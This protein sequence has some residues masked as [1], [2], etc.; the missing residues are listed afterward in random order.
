LNPLFEKEA[1]ERERKVVLE[2]IKMYHDNPSSH[3]M[4]KIKEVMYKSPFGLPIL[5]TSETV[6]KLSRE[7]IVKVFDPVYSGNNLIFC[8]VG[9]SNFDS[10][11][12]EA[13]KFP[14]KISAIKRIPIIPKNGEVT[15]TREG[16]DQAHL[17]FGTHLPNLS[18]KDRYA[19]EILD[20]FLTGGMSSV[21]FKEG[22]EKRGL[23]YS[24]H[25]I[26]DQSKDYAHEL[27]YTGTTKENVKEIKEIILREFKNIKF[28][29]QADLNVIKER[30]IGLR[31]ISREKSD[32]TMINLLQEELAGNPEEYYK[33]DER[34]NAV[35]LLM[36]KIFRN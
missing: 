1:L 2:E 15:E 18:Q 21:L 31:K 5:G 25:G 9:D 23:C 4:E 26:L 28:M 34:I 14:K 11:L 7:K 13:K 27:I 8:V 32:S 35:K 19:C 36:F 20:S 29:K 17:V 3:V 30:L 33:Y 16:L 10:V 6:S 12:N 22:R 24:I